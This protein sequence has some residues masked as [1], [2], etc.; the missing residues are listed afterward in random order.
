MEG[1]RPGDVDL[2]RSVTIALPNVRKA[3]I[4]ETTPAPGHPITI[5]T[6]LTWDKALAKIEKLIQDTNAEA[7]RVDRDTLVYSVEHS[8]EIEVGGQPKRREPETA[9]P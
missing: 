1:V 7:E 2:T 6:C 8:G 4:G 5:E 9:D 3:L